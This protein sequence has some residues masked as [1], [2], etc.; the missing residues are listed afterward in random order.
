M[1]KPSLLLSLITLGASAAHADLRAVI[2]V[3]TE[4]GGSSSRSGSHEV[5]IVRSGTKTRIQRTDETKWVLVEESQ[6]W[7]VDDTA[8]TYALMPARQSPS[9]NLKSDIQVTPTSEMKD[10]QGLS[11]TKFDLSG[12][13]TLSSSGAGRGRLGGLRRGGGSSSPTINVT[14]SLWGTKEVTGVS[15]SD[16]LGERGALLAQNEKLTQLGLILEGQ[17]RIQVPVIAGRGGQDV[18]F[19]FATVS[20]DQ[21]AQDAKLLTLPDG[22]R[23]VDPP[24][25]PSRRGGFGGGFPAG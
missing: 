10:I 18:R 19:E 2:K 24:K 3:Q 20:L 8:K 13:V 1:L 5:T 12:A 7:L 21:G 11:A 14:G 23:K 22:Y 16:F 4:G 9:G 17:M 6:R 15:L 25:P